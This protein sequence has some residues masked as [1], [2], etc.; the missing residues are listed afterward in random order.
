MGEMWLRDTG[1]NTDAKLSE[2]TDQQRLLG[3]TL[4]PVSRN[5]GS[6][7]PIHEENHHLQQA[8]E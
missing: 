7:D 1:E 6:Q 4:P 8:I 3:S 2:L 5:F